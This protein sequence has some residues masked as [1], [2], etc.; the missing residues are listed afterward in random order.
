MVLKAICDCVRN[1]TLSHLHNARIRNESELLRRCDQSQEKA[2][3]CAGKSCPK[4]KQYIFAQKRL[5][6]LRRTVQIVGSV[7]LAFCV[8][9]NCDMCVRVS[10][11]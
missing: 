9:A 7:C 8:S 3:K 5:I 1:L 2:S 11:M 10:K 4:L 6:F